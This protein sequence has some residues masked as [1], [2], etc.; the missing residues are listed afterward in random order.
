MTCT[1]QV[2]EINI[3]ITGIDIQTEI[4]EIGMIKIAMWIITGMKGSNQEE[5]SIMVTIKQ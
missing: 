3:D 1:Q 4:L 2:I 5:I